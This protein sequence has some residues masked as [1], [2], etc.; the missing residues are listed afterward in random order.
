MER[1]KDRRVQIEGIYREKNYNEE[2]LVKSINET[3]KTELDKEASKLTIAGTLATRFNVNSPYLIL[4]LEDTAE[5]FYMVNKD[6]IQAG[7]NSLFGKKVIIT[8]IKARTSPRDK[9]IANLAIDIR[10]GD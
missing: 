10:R 5:S 8:Y 9:D 6:F 7:G 3:T 4:S 1:F 2:I